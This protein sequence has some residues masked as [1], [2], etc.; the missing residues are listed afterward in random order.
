M[1]SAVSVEPAG[2]IRSGRPCSLSHSVAERKVW[3]SGAKMANEMWKTRSRNSWVSN[4]IRLDG[5]HEA[6]RPKTTTRTPASEAKVRMVSDSTGNGAPSSVDGWTTAMVWIA[7][8]FIAMKSE[9][10]RIESCART[11]SREQ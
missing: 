6:A 2:S 9:T 1:M 5:T 10:A 4:E 3:V 8:M 7:A 11:T